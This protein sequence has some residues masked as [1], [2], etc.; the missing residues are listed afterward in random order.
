[1]IYKVT[2]IPYFGGIITMTIRCDNCSLRVTDIMAISEKGELPAMQKRITFR[3]NMGDLVI[4]S[5]GSKIEVPE[6]GIEVYISRENGGEITTIEG[7]LRDI[8]DKVISLM[9]NSSSEGKMILENILRKIDNE[10][11]APSGKLSIILIDKNQKSAIISNELWTK[12]VEEERSKMVSLDEIKRLGE[13]II[14]HYKDSN[15]NQF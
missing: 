6:I 9:K 12:R 15:F 10:L 13:E 5:A 14:E 7:I 1:M 2:K 4:L 8:R 3:Q 11:N